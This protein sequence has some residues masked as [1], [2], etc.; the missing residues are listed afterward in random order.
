M[1]KVDRQNERENRIEDEILV[2]AYT[3]EEQALGWYYYLKDG[4]HF[5]FSARWVTQ[6][7]RENP[8]KWERVDVIGMPDEE[9]CMGDMYVEIRYGDGD[10]ADGFSV[11]ISDIECLEEDENEKRRQ[12]I[13]DWHYWIDMGYELI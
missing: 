5:P 3:E 13:E 2:D 11:P 1:V 6:E 8:Q 4:L 9:E 10:L 12:C 7:T